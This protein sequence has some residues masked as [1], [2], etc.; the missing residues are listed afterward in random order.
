MKQSTLLLLVVVAGIA[1]L[2][3]LK[4][5]PTEPQTGLGLTITQDS[6]GITYVS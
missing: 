6:F 1:A 5:K 3:L 4:K 2:F